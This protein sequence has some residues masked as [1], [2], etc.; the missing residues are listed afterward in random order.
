MSEA[1]LVKK[2]FSHVAHDDSDDSEDEEVRLQGSD[3][4]SEATSEDVARQRG[5]SA[6]K[7][8]DEPKAVW[9]DEDDARDEVEGV[10]INRI[11]GHKYPKL[12]PT[13]AVSAKEYRKRLRETYQ[14]ASH[15]GRTPKWA[16]IAPE[17]DASASRESDDS[18]GDEVMGALREMTKSTGKYITKS[19][20]LAKTYLATNKLKDIT[21]GHAKGSLTV[22]KFHP[23][24]PVLVTG[25]VAGRIALFEVRLKFVE[26]ADNLR[27]KKSD[28][29]LQEVEFQKFGVDFAEF[30]DGGAYLMAG[31][32][33]NNYFFSYDLLEGKVSQVRRPQVMPLTKQSNKFAI[34]HDG[35]LIAMIGSTAD[36]YV[37][38]I[39][40]MEH[41]HTFYATGRVIDVC[42][43]SSD[44]NVIYAMTDNGTVYAWD[45]RRKGEQNFFRDEGSVRGTGLATI[46]FE[47]GADF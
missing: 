8:K 7:S 36:V 11:T 23:S 27:L 5:S 45:L 35:T 31:S 6:G 32:S 10:Q 2:L 16:K 25:S 47:T 1:A 21:V 26:D 19:T 3:S 13:D 15:V 28:S 41:M 34:S 38:A 9:S 44:N 18:E 39:K 20:V 4:E 12:A 37:F 30:Y 24:R 22:V 42:F 14:K 17:G 46:H 33:R 29:F 40:A 43:S